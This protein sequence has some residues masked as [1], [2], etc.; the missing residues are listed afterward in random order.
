MP[1]LIT[2]WPASPVLAGLLVEV[3]E[4]GIPVRVLAALDRLGF[5]LQAEAFRP[6]QIGNGVGTD[7]VPGPGQ[8]PR[9]RAGGLH[10][11]PQRRHRIAPY[12]RLYQRQQR[13]PQN[14]IPRSQV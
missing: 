14:R 12:I 4:L 7:A 9:E 6:Q 5:N 13:G 8:L 3:A 1:T 10:R 11:P 2:G